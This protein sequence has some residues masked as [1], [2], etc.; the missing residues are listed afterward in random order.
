M[1]DAFDGLD[2]RIGKFFRTGGQG[3]GQVVKDQVFGSQPVFVDGNIVNP[4]GNFEFAFGGFGHALLVD[5]EH[6]HGGVVFAG[7]F[8]DLVGL[9]APAFQVSG[10]D[11]AAS[12]G[13]LEGS[14]KHIDLGGVDHQRQTDDG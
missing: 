7:Q 4:S 3:E 9:L 1:F 11:Q 10:V 5:G 6:D 13:V 2:G 14:L 8:E 12:G